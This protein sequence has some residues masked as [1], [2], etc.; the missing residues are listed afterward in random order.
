MNFLLTVTFVTRSYLYWYL[1][2]SW[3]G[4]RRIPFSTHVA[5]ASVLDAWLMFQVPARSCSIATVMVFFASRA[6]GVRG[7]CAQA[8]AND[9]TVPGAAAAALWLVAAAEPATASTA[10]AATTRNQ[11]R[12]CI[13]DSLRWSAPGVLGTAAPAH[14]D[15]PLRRDHRRSAREQEVERMRVRRCERH[16]VPRRARLRRVE[17]AQGAQRRVL[18]GGSDEYRRHDSC[19]RGERHR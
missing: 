13:D 16:V 15:A 1:F 6:A 10:A 5:H 14:S 11:I 12:L 17:G 7:V 18:A 8:L 19:R 9:W 2:V 3:Y 4:L